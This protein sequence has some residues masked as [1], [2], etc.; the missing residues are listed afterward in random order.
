MKDPGWGLLVP[1]THQM[2]KVVIF[3]LGVTLITSCTR[4][5]VNSD[6]IADN[7][8][9]L[10]DSVSSSPGSKQDFS[11]YGQTDSTFT[12][13]DKVF[14]VNVKQFDL[15]EKAIH[16]GDTMSRPVYACAVRI[17]DMN[18][19]VVYRDSLLRDSWGY[20]GKIVPID[21]YQ[22]ALPQLRAEGNEIILSFHI[23]EE[24][25]GDAIDGFIA[26]DISAHTD[27]YYWQEAALGE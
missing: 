27:R 20:P 12:M 18:K 22:I 7:A 3:L 11:L 6:K 15:T 25:D 19:K 2:K 24:Y 13:H 14:H 4:S 21:A 17:V 1:W 9:K 26:F 23:Y 8:E 10:T 16:E 5:S